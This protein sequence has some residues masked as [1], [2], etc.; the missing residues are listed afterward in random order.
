LE[1]LIEQA[2]LTVTASGEAD[3][4]FEYPDL[5]TA[6]IAGRSAG[7]VQGALRQVAEATLRDNV[8]A[9]I[10]RYRTST[11]AVRFENTFRVVTAKP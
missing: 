3:C 10:A 5:E 1:G 8:L 4:P 9:A 7:P 11:G 6:W 2:G